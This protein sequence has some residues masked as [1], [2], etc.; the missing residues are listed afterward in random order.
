MGEHR[1]VKGMNML[2]DLL[3]SLLIQ[4]AELSIEGGKLKVHAREGLLRPEVVSTLRQSKDELL[5]LLPD[6]SFE[7]PLSI[8]QEGLWFIQQAAPDSSAYN[9][10]IPLR[11]ESDADPGP[12]LRRALQ[13]LFDR[14]SLLRTSYVAV[15]GSP[16]Q[17]IHASRAVDLVE[18]DVAGQSWAEVESAATAVIK[19]PFDLA[20]EGAFRARLFRKSPRESLL[21]LCLHHIAV[22]GWS[23]ALM[24]DELLR[25]YEA[26]GR[27]NPLPPIK[28]TYQAYV[29]AQR[30]TLAARGES[31]R[32]AWMAELKGAP[33]VLELPTDRPRPP[34]Q[35]FRGATYQRTLS[36]ALSD[37]LSELARKKGTTLATILLTAYQL[38]LHRYSGQEDFCV[39]FG[40]SRRDHQDFVGTFGYMVNRVVI[41][42]QL[43][44]DADFLRLIEQT[45]AR[46]VT[47][48]DLQDYPFPWLV[49]D[50]LTER[51][52]SREPVAQVSFVF[53]QGRASNA[54]ID[55]LTGATIQVAGTRFA[56]V[57]LHQETAESELILEVTEGP[58]GRVLGFRYNTDLFD[59]ATIVQMAGH[60]ETLLTEIARDPHRPVSQIP[61]LTE[62]ERRQIIVEWNR[63]V[64]PFSQDACIHQLFEA[65]VDRAPEAVALV[66]LCDRAA[67]DRGVA[68]T[69]QELER[70]ANQVAHLLVGLGVG[71]ETRVAL[72][73]ERSASL[74]VALLGVLKAGCAFVVLDKEHPERRL[75]FILQD[76]GA[77][78]IL[79]RG[80]MR[81]GLPETDAR[82]VDLDV[83]LDAAASHRPSATAGPSNLA[84]VLYT[85]G[86]TGEPNGVLIEHRGLVNSIEAHIRMME[87]GPDTRLA[88]VSSFSF[89]GAIAHLFT[90]L[91]SGGAVYLAPRDS[92]FL[93]RGLVTLMEREAIT[94]LFLVPTMLAALPEAALP[95]LRTIVS[96]G[97][98]C[99]AELVTRWGRGRSFLNLYGPT[100]VSIVATGTRCVA[101]GTSPPIGRPIA[102]LRAYIVDRWGQLAPPGVVGELW[103]GG[104]G[105]ARGY[106]N[107]PELT[108]RK[109]ID[110]P[111]AEGGGRLYRT[112]DLVRY[113]RVE[114]ALPVLEF[115]G[116]SDNQVKLRGFRIELSEV[117]STLRASKK[118]RDAVATVVPNPNRLV[119]YVAPAPWERSTALE[120]EQIAMWDAMPFEA[121]Q[122]GDLT[123]D[124]RG[125]KS[126]YTGEDIAPAEM[127]AWAESTVARILEL[128]P[129]TVLEVGCGTGMLLTRIAPHVRRYRATDLA[130][131]AVEHVERMK[132]QSRGLEQVTVTRQPAHDFSGLGGERF[133]TIVMNSTV[134]YFPSADYLVEVIGGLLGLMD[135]E[136]ALFIGDVR[137]LA[138]LRTYH[139]SVERYRSGGTLSRR[140]LEHRIEQ[141][142]SRENE[143]VLHPRFFTALRAK[144]PQIVDVEIAP[145]RGSY[146]NELSLYRYDVVLRVGRAPST[147]ASIPWR[148]VE[149]E[150]LNSEELRDLVAS[151]APGHT[152]GLRGVPNARLHEDNAWLRWLSDPEDHLTPRQ[153]S[154]SAPRACDPE[155]VYEIGQ[156]LSCCVKLS[157]ATGRADGSFDALL[158]KGGSV[159]RFPL[160]ESAAPVRLAELANDPLH[161]RR[162]RDLAAELGQELREVLPPHLVP[163]AIVVL[164]A[165]PRTVSG[166]VDLKAL[167][168][169]EPL[170]EPSAGAAEPRNDTERKLAKVWCA[171]LGL[172][173]VGIHD[174]FFELGGDSILS[175]QIVAQAQAAG[176]SLRAGQFFEH[177]TIALLAAA[178]AHGEAKPSEKGPVYGEVPLTPIQQWFFAQRL[179]MP[180]HFNQAVLIETPA[181]LDI[182]RLQRALRHL[183]FHH[184]AL[185]MRFTKRDSHFT[186]ECMPS[187]DEIAFEYVDLSI[188]APGKRRAAIERTAGSLQRSLDILAGPLLRVAYFSCGDSEPG[189]LLWIVHHLVI[190]AVSWRVLLSDLNTAYRQL[191][192]GK[193][194]TL[195][196]KTTSFKRWAERLSAYA[197]SADFAAERAVLALE[198]PVP[199]PLDHPDG[200]NDRRSA[201]ELRVRL[202]A[203]ATRSLLKDA[204]LPY[205]LGVQDLLLAAVAQAV[206]G[207]TGSAD[208]WLDLEGHG[209][210]ELFDDV[211]LSRTVGWFTSLAP[212]C[213]RLPAKSDAAEV[214][215]SIKEQL[216]AM[217]RRGIGYGILRYLHEEGAGLSWPT[218]QISFN[219][220]GRY[221]SDE[222]HPDAFRLAWENVGPL[223]SPTGERPH[224][225]DINCLVAE[226]QLELAFGYSQQLLDEATMQRLARGV[227]AA[228]EG[229]IGHCLSPGAGAWTPSDFPLA[230]LNRRSL[231][232]VLE[233]LGPSQRLQIAAIYELTPMQRGLLFHLLRDGAASVYSTQIVLQLEGALDA[234][235]FRA[236]W[237]HTVRCHPLL[238]SC[239]VWEGLEEPVQVVLRE[240]ALPWV[241][242]DLRGASDVEARLAEIGAALEARP[243]PLDKAPVIRLTLVRT[244]ERQYALFYDCHHLLADGWSL[245]IVLQGVFEAYQAL[246]SGVPLPGAAFGSYENYLRWLRKQDRQQAEAYWR[247]TLQGFEA[248]TPLAVESSVPLSQPS[249][250]VH[251][252]TLS[253]ELTARLDSVAQEQHITLAS[254]FEGA[255]ALL[256]H[257]YSGH[258]DVLLGKVTSGRDVA[259]PGIENMFGLFIHTLPARVRV[260]EDQD[261]WTWLRAYQTSQ[262]EARAHQHLSLAEIQRCSAVPFGTELFRS[263]LAVVNYPVDAE[264]FRRSGLSVSV[265]SGASPTNYPLVVRAVPGQKLVLTFDY[266][267]ALFDPSAIERM[268]GHLEQI[269]CGIAGASATTRLAE[270]P[271]LPQAEREQVVVAWN[272]TAR[273]HDRSATIHGL[274]AAQAAR[275]PFAP[276]VY[277]GER[278]VSYAELERRAN[279]LARYLRRKG[280]SAET[281]VAVCLDRTDAMIVALLAILKAGGAYVPIDPTYPLSRQ[282]FMAADSGA[283]WIVSARSLASDFAADRSMIITIDGDAARIEAEDAA[284]IGSDVTPDRL[285]YIIYTSGSTGQPKG[286]AIEHRNTVAMLHSALGQYAPDDLTVVSACASICF[287]YSILEIF[288]PLI[289]GGAVLVANDSLALL[290]AP[291]RDRVRLLSVV[292]SAMSELHRSGRLPSGIRAINLA[293]E[294][295]SNELVQRVYGISGVERVYNIYGPTETTTYSTYALTQRGAESD[296]PLGRP[297]ANTR[298]YLLDRRMRP[299]PVGVP[300]E[301]FIGGEGVSRGYWNRPGLTQERFVT[302]SFGP[303]R[304]YRTGD[305]GRFRADGEIEYLGR[306]DHQIKIRG[307]RVELGEIEAALERTPGV[308]KAVVVADGAAPQKR[309]VAHF[310][311]APGQAPTVADLRARLAAS[312][313]SFMVPEVYLRHDAFPLTASG[314]IDRRALPSPEDADLQHSNYLA[315]ET[316]LEQAMA[317]IWR[318]ILAVPRIGA[319]DNFFR[320]GGHSLLA[321]NMV[322]RVEAELGHSISIATLFQAPTLRELARMMTATEPSTQPKSSLL[323]PIQPKGSRPPVFCVGGFGVHASYLHPLGPALGEDQPL[324]AIQP[325]DLSEDMPEV[326]RLEQLASRLAD[327]VQGVQ[328]EG[329]YVLSG[330][331][332]GARLALAIALELEARGP[333]TALVVL[334]MHAPVHGGARNDRWISDDQ[335]LDYLRQMKVV[336]G[337]TLAV[338]LEATA[339][340]PDE[341]AWQHIAD[342]LEREQLLPAG[343]GVPM[344]KRTIGLRERVFTLLADFVPSQPYSGPIVLLSVANRH[345]IGLPRISPESWQAYCSRPIESHIVPGDHFTML[346]EPHVAVVAAHLRR[347][348]DAQRPAASA[349]PAAAFPVSWSDPADAEAMW[350]FDAAHSAEPMS[351]LD[352]DLR[353]APMTAG[354]NHACQV[355]GL[356]LRSEPRLIHSFVYQKAIAP[357]L[358]TAATAAAF[359]GADQS[360]RHGGARL[361]QSWSGAWLPEIKEHL[362]ALHA[363][364]LAG[365]SLPALVEH[366]VDIRRRVVRLW[367]LH[368]ELMYPVTL[369]LS[370]FDDAY[371]DLFPDAKQLEVYE[372]LS[373]FPS[374]TTEANLRLWEIGRA[375]ARTPALHALIVETPPEGLLAALANSLEGQA[376]YAEIQDY[377]RIYGERG[378]D[379]YIDRPTWNEVPIAV[380][381][382]LREAALQPTRDLAAELQQQVERREARERKVR[383]ALAGHPHPVVEEFEALLAAAQASAHLGEEH[384][385][386]IDAKITFHARR[387]ALEVG[388]RLAAR[389]V[390]GD[391]EDVF[392]L[393]L[394][395]L[396]ALDMAALPSL[397]ATVARRQAELAHYTGFK[398]PGVL[399]VPR[400]FLPMDS[401]MM[402]AMFRMNGD[403]MSPP[404]KSGTLDGMP[405]ARGRI[406]GPARIVRTLAEAGKLRPG[407]VLVAT[408]TLPSWTPYFAIAAAVVT[409]TGGMLC[410]AAVVAREYGIPAV[411]G[412]R[413]ATALLKD[414]QLIEVDGDAGLVRVVVAAG[415]AG[416]GPA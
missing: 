125:W 329:P 263:L 326:T 287:D 40:V 150:G 15:D 283:S 322:L 83:S 18:I 89:D 92:D 297:I 12:K 348:V 62:A 328:S 53:Q 298:V 239:F 230:H 271:L 37:A 361:A 130:Q 272:Q 49:K 96:A 255:W 158:T 144:F 176:I 54:T 45:H 186:Q 108:A 299:V 314:K 245:G 293:G 356:P 289:A 321:L 67:G 179:P 340:M 182:E 316:P 267:T 265:R 296:P 355:Y 350:I 227:L 195:P 111:F 409:D 337:E 98:R 231:D 68:L 300:G 266:D 325:L 389:G 241:E 268:A 149:R 99:S 341:Q 285:A 369:A 133:D 385:F 82:V 29:T 331:S 194:V 140:E 368:F 184:D 211:D 132:Q 218:P 172:A 407:D 46:S 163:S 61:L 292:P 270:L 136:G 219:Y 364:D 16:R 139:L 390:I 30:E 35:T 253:A 260:D 377:L 100:E 58:E 134:Q 118:V 165:L 161:G 363:F 416:K 120:L 220:L 334:D 229:L 415:T 352:F 72:Y 303:G 87:T 279:R 343:G 106:L 207:W 393:D 372:L 269:L 403:R 212:L 192:L 175:I 318:E 63:T 56:A 164:S 327:L 52:P 47:A 324:Y 400:P 405:G 213:L 81:A 193:E 27:P 310:I 180:N 257:H 155:S 32:R 228:L 281:R 74:I 306:I 386:W 313:P 33:L 410:H 178:A 280:I 357:K 117:E 282:A 202:P 345:R 196:A 25:L 115:V 243:L 19:Q 362:A 238:R 119:G 333:R 240:V 91:G 13:K 8:E 187:L 302:D 129:R 64:A 24:L 10:G 382:S 189:R 6:F 142:L 387:A 406:T 232:N 226:G 384:N 170:P 323:I 349:S 366:L 222:D 295:L 288:L 367:E 153:P 399:G 152:L 173:K 374:K 1:A 335:L 336:L 396:V 284:P 156:A 398:P 339:K 353:T 346:R 157:W 3:Q 235:A 71:R 4:G 75:S 80:S 383:A 277:Y 147:P 252:R 308:E 373:G 122:T 123:L 199:L 214:L 379:L 124:L 101:D 17:V 312:L 44:A 290:D 94:H 380:L 233:R 401:A 66:D 305:L 5:R 378:D 221:H 274:V 177:P 154:Q 141:A 359:A 394:A 205:N 206:S 85:S 210:E 148:D 110:D 104:V 28:R 190:D 131:H 14:H 320:L 39:G 105:V 392:H 248:P 319:N 20:A 116:R 414:G 60:M 166:K 286:V 203:E 365:A 275:T 90:P 102:N 171:V 381:R 121:T 395:E 413:A 250:R 256:L 344:L 112:G 113:R 197:Q 31:L 138:L 38:V 261:V 397:H 309:L 342:L 159:P 402:R 208:V 169:P 42:S 338:D 26:D 370:D 55:L 216:R 375:A 201:A 264:I 411:V 77:S 70:R 88:H 7:M 57:Y 76:T 95:A 168:P 354:I 246:R 234:G 128:T 225:L 181:D 301:I 224:V 347:V 223:H 97:E 332:A 242:H 404:S 41:R 262:V 174:N 258:D 259:V 9:V 86:S 65:Q 143:L 304:L 51:D 254:C 73:L 244:G 249:V 412:T 59:S 315:P 36:P 167:P 217:P 388:R 50:L 146:R 330:H 198:P 2:T 43:D 145:K 23:V 109:F 78:V 22:D 185:R 273:E 371:R 79:T 209:R 107:R 114:G 183:V 307:F 126:S 291:A 151:L 127:R 237:E 188:L 358:D 247:R 360:L 160:P 236:A 162:C 48:L 351:R 294:K 311:A 376:L 21:L 69:Y 137:N 135:E 200:H 276:A 93:G 34:V 11:V 278:V 215:I 317:E 103:I 251:T 391:P 84:Y 191:A 408:A 204:L